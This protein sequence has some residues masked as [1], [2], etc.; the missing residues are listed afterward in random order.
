MTWST[1][2][3]IHHGLPRDFFLGAE[4]NMAQLSLFYESQGTDMN[5]SAPDERDTE[6]A[7]LVSKKST[8]FPKSA[9][10]KLGTDG[11]N[12]NSQT[13]HKGAK[14]PSQTPRMLTRMRASE[15]VLANWSGSDPN[16]SI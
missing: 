14:T 2:L 8:E 11:S 7:D 6:M 4:K 1:K 9:S 3:S 10:L 15:L 5:F 13:C 12:S 16:H